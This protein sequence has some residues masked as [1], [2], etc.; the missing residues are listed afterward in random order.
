MPPSRSWM[1][2]ECKM[3]CSNRPNVSTRICRFLP[4]ISLPASN[5]CGSMQGPFFGALDALAVDDGGGGA[6]LAL[7]LL[8]AFDVERVMN[9]IEHAVAVPPHE[10]AVHRALRWKILRKV[11]P[12]AAGAQDVHDPVHDCPHLLPPIAA[13]G[14]AGGMNGS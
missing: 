6:G 5:P 7:R 3:A 2:A 8:A 14:F 13:P 11:A 9:A 4:L 12:L 10:I 1:P